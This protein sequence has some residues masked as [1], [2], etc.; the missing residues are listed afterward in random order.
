[1]RYKKKG[2]GAATRDSHNPT[3][4]SKAYGCLLPKSNTDDVPVSR[5]QAKEWFARIREEI[6]N[7]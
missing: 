4:H 2:S 3:L 5:A 6:R 1:V 7:G